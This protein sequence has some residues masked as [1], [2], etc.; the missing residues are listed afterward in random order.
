[1]DVGH[2]VGVAVIGRTAGGVHVRPGPVVQVHVDFL[3]AQRP[4]R[5]VHRGGNIFRRHVSVPELARDEQVVGRGDVAQPDRFTNRFAHDVFIFIRAGRV[6]VSPSQTDRLE[7]RVFHVVLRP[8]RVERPE[9]RHRHPSAATE[10]HR[11]NR[12]RINRGN[13]CV[14]FNGVYRDGHEGLLSGT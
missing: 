4:Q 7:R 6:D 1:M 10:C 13:G 3:D 5:A 11:A 8:I 2:R 14:K 12:G 9:G